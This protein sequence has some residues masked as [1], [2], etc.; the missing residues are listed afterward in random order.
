MV[1]ITE[2]GI[3]NLMLH[4]DTAIRI[5]QPVSLFLG[6][7]EQGKTT[8]PSAVRWALD[9][10]WIEPLSLT[11]LPKKDHGLLIRKGQKK[12]EVTVKMA[13]GSEYARTRTPSAATG[14]KYAFKLSQDGLNCLFDSTYFYRMD[15]KTRAKMLFDLLG[16]NL[17]TEQTFSEAHNLLGDESAKMFTASE[18]TRM[19]TAYA[20]KE[21]AGARDVVI[22]IRRECKRELDGLPREAPGHVFT[23]EYEKFGKKITKDIDIKAQN[24]TSEIVKTKIKDL[25]IARDG[26]VENLGKLEGGQRQS[27]EWIRNE[28]EAKRKHLAEADKRIDGLKFD[29]AEELAKLDGQINKV[30]QEVEQTRERIRRLEYDLENIPTFEGGICPTCERKLTQAVEKNF[31]SKASSV[32]SELDG[33]R[34]IH[35]N[36]MLELNGLT[37]KRA[38]IALGQT[39]Y[40]ELTSKRAVL[41]EEID[42][43]EKSESDA[44]ERVQQR[45][46]AEALKH[47]IEEMSGMLSGFELLQAELSGYDQRLA[48]YESAGKKT[49]DLEAKIAACNSLDTL[50]G[51]GNDSLVARLTS[52]ARGR[53]NK[54]LDH[55]TK[56]LGR[57][58][59]LDEELNPVFSDSLSETVLSTSA[60]RR[61]GIAMQAAIAILSEFKFFVTDD[62]ENL[63]TDLRREL[64]R[65][66]MG[67]SKEFGLQ[68]WILAALGKEELERTRKGFAKQPIPGVQIFITEKGTIQ[69]IVKEAA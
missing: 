12:A 61:A 19:K 40:A 2:V 32:K 67:L 43:L 54:I 42:R 38:P 64:V 25:R 29:A 58:V 34:I 13:D 50:F 26:L 65:C 46:E 18:W 52:D 31:K 63:D 21:L 36:Q 49:S 66:A 24:L 56:L 51:T 60:K 62:S 39:E 1:A 14:P 28:L 4:G 16:L 3:K 55:F 9:E 44:Q 17:T 6:L 48:E 57:G 5:N 10:N 41:R 30:K 11:V 53:I 8:I 15:S 27:L 68:I 20:T 47:D 22:E 23:I 59:Q 45:D 69:E 37:E 7:S 33:Q 35:D